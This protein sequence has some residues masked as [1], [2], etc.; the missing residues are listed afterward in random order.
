MLDKLSRTEPLIASFLLLVLLLAGVAVAGILNMDRSQAAVERI[1]NQEL[2]GLSAVQQASAGMAH[3]DRVLDEMALARS[4][5]ERRELAGRLDGYRADMRTQLEVARPLFF[6]GGGHALFVA[7]EQSVRRYEEAIPEAISRLAREEPG[8]GRDG[9]A[10]LFDEVRPRAHD[11]HEG[12]SELARHKALVAEQYKAA[13]SENYRNRRALMLAVCAASLGVGLGLGGLVL[14]RPMR[15]L[16]GEPAIA[17]DA[18]AGIADGGWS[19]P[20]ACARGRP[21]GA[22]AGQ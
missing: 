11:A 8:A 16:A 20:L 10:Y 7:V 14:R 15:I 17:R 3:I 19:L 1:H 22:H 12:L 21:A 6:A 13:L 9:I 18:A 4:V 5:A 2:L